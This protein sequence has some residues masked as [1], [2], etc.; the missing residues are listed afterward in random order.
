[1]LF[2]LI[3]GIR[4][5]GRSYAERHY[6]LSYGEFHT[7]LESDTAFSRW[8]KDIEADVVDLATG[9]PWRGEGPFP[10]GRWTRVLLLQQLLVELF[11]ILDPDCV[12]LPASR[13]ERLMPVAWGPLPRLSLYQK[14]LQE[15]S[16]ASDFGGHQ[17]ALQGL[18]DLDKFRNIIASIDANADT[19]KEKSKK[20]TGRDSEASS[21]EGLTT[22]NENGPLA[23][24]ARAMQMVEGF[25]INNGFDVNDV[26]DS[27]S[28][29]NGSD[30]STKSKN[31]R[32]PAQGL[33]L[34]ELEKEEARAA[35]RA[36]VRTAH[37]Q[38]RIDAGDQT[39]N[40]KD[41]QKE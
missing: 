35:V 13:R 41:I 16:N 23:E 37:L 7:R 14:R 4:H 36:A 9:P 18:R 32:P 34:A 11:D 29:S 2:P 39:K 3:V 20:K 5:H 15:L 27:S 40:K 30:G 17:A 31:R 28:S 21:W 22:Q 38:A 33:T 12:R 26:N 19:S 6:T 10:V 25:R 8:F 1:M 24:I